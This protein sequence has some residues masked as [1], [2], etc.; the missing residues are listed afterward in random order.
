[1]RKRRAIG[2]R[3]LALLALAAGCFGTAQAAFDLTRKFNDSDLRRSGQ[4]GLPAWLTFDRV[5]DM[6][7]VEQ[8]KRELR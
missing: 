1:M 2:R 7:F 8:A 4:P 5:A 6:R 3:M